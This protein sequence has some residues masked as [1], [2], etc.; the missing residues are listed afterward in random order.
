[1]S[2]YDNE[3]S[4]ESYGNQQSG[5][6]RQ[7]RYGNSEDTDNYGSSNNNDDSYGGKS[8]YQCNPVMLSMFRISSSLRRTKPPSILFYGMY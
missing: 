3:D 2:S 8:H 4:S 5:N 1:M 7:E 6:Q